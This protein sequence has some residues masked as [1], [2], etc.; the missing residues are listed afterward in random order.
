M[1]TGLLVAGLLVAAATLQFAYPA[2]A[3]AGCPSCYGFVDAGDRVFIERGTT[4]DRR[5][6]IRTVIAE[7]QDR[8]RGFYGSLDARPRI[9]IC[10]TQDCYEWFGGRSRGV[11]VLDWVLV[12]SPRGTDAVIAAHE[13]AHIELHSRVGLL[14]TLTRAVPQ[15]FDEG[16]AVVVSDDPRYLTSDAREDRCRVE[17][18]GAMPSSRAAWIESAES[19]GLYAKAAC[20]VSR[21]LHGHGGREAV[22][23]T[24]AALARAA[25]FEQAVR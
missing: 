20:R 21:W 17:P 6:Q 24:I 5:A 22:L 2:I 10:A 19:A 1:R 18:D 16:L 3:T 23:R 9:L 25:D 4:P 8:V 14:G 15:W 7:A 11:A 12:L 13:L